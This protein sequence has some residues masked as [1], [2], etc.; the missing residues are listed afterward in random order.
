M[1]MTMATT[2]RMKSEQFSRTRLRRVRLFSRLPMLVETEGAWFRGGY[3]TS[4]KLQANASKH[5]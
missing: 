3:Q 5:Q 1:G 2:K 4:W